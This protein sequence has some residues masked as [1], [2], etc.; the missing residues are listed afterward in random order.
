MKQKE[1]NQLDIVFLLQIPTSIYFALP[2]GQGDCTV[3]QCP[4]A[5]GGE[6]S[7]IDAG[8]SANTGFTKTQVIDAFNGQTVETII[9]THP[10]DDHI[11]YIED[12][13][14]VIKGGIPPIYHPCDWKHILQ[15]KTIKSA[16][17][18][19]NATR[20]WTMLWSWMYVVQDMQ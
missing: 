13:L 15:R 20:N 10:H 17:I 6:I 11:N 2:V 16:K 4:S 7:I 12:I 8:S 5:Y 19:A 1:K 18:K 9:L 3:I 14:K